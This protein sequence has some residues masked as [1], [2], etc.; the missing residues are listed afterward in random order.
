MTEET[1]SVDAGNPEPTVGAT[2]EAASAATSFLDSVKDADLRGWAENKQFPG[3]EQ[4]LNSY[5]NLE[6]MMGADKAGR[7]VTLLGDDA[8]PEQRGEFYTKLGRPEAPDAYSFKLDDGA[9]TSRLDALRTVAHEAGLSDAQFKALAEAD[10]NYFTEH[11]KAAEESTHMSEVDATAALKREWGAAFDQNVAGVERYATQLG[12]T[13]EQLVGLSKSMGPVEAMKF[14]HSL[15]SRLGEDT[16]DTG[17]P[18]SG[19]LTPEQAR[20]SLRELNM[21]KEFMEAWLEKSHPGHAAAVDK[22]AALARQAAGVL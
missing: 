7:T 6:K 2:M 4:A 18:V 8:T 16:V 21:N 9:D 10:V 5:R 17:E 11:T 1:G 14:V 3:V 15:G 22:K 19:V 12:M 13:E 20:T